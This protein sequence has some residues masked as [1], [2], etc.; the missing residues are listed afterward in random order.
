M[1]SRL[2]ISPLRNLL[3]NRLKT[4]STSLNLASMVPPWMIRSRFKT[5]FVYF[6]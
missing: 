6:Q 4:A 5:Q 1:Y 2:E 3:F